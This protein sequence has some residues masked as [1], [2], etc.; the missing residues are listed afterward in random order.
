MAAAHNL[1]YTT[2]KLPKKTYFPFKFKCMNAEGHRDG[3]AQIDR[4]LIYDWPVV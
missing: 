2:T 1:T 4:V 3:I